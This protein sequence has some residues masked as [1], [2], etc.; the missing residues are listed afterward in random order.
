M[1]FPSVCAL[2]SASFFSWFLILGQEPNAMCRLRWLVPAIFEPLLYAK[3]C[4]QSLQQARVHPPGIA[5]IVKC[6][7]TNDFFL[8]RL[9]VGGVSL[10]SGLVSLSSAIVK[11]KSMQEQSQ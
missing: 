5:S 10:L 3:V 2:V 9:D 8:L 7:H 1:I 6:S 11:N 4:L